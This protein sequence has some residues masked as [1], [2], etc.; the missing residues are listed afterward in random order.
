M[1]AVPARPGPTA[2]PWASLLLLIAGLAAL[3]QLV[4][5]WRSARLPATV[6][7]GGADP[8]PTIQA[9]GVGGWRFYRALHDVTPATFELTLGR[10]IVLGVAGA[11]LALV[12]LGLLCLLPIDHRPFGT[13]ALLVSGFCVLGCVFLL[14]RA[15][16][17]FGVGLNGLFDQAQPGFYV[18]LA[19]GLIGV[20]G[21]FKAL[22]AR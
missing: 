15:R 6:G 17:F 12:L 22:A 3:V 20:A 2:D 4:L 8:D 11:G 1:T 9:I 21:A 16:T 13:V 7:P 14:A 10:Y 18:L 5:P 19:A